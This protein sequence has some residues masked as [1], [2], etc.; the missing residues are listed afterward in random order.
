MKQRVKASMTVEAALLY[1]Y[2]LLVTFLLVKVTVYRYAEVQMQA[3]RLYDTVFTERK[4]ETSELLRMADTAFE[5]F[6]KV[7]R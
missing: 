5:L 4:T 6:E 2:L 3:A 1:P 7:K